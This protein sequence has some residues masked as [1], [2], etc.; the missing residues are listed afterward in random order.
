ME[1]V[2]GTNRGRGGSNG[3][4]EACF[5]VLP[6][7]PREGRGV[8]RIASFPLLT[9]IAPASDHLTI[10]SPF[11]LWCRSRVDVSSLRRAGRIAA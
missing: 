9:R 10:Q 2:A 3:G 8:K 5:E 11:Y 7:A 1:R 6:E 4:D